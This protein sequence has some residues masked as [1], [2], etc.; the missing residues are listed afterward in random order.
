MPQRPDPE[1][2]AWAS[3]AVR[4]FAAATNLLVAGR[5]VRVLGG[6]PRDAAALVALLTGL[7]ARTTTGRDAADPGPVDQL[8]CLGDPEE[9]TVAVER[10]ADR[11]R[12]ST[13]VVVDAGRY[14]PRSTRTPSARSP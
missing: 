1:R 13:L 3:A 2:A 11:P 12:G 7:G 8:W 4:R 10:E 6:D 9:S 5:T 14:A